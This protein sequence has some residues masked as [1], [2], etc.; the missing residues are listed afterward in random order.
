MPVNLAKLNGP[1]MPPKFRVV[2]KNTGKILAPD[3]I[4]M[5]ISTGRISCCD[6]NG[7]HCSFNTAEA[8]VIQSIGRKDRDGEEVFHGDVLEFDQAGFTSPERA[9][10]R[11]DILGM[12][13]RL[14]TSKGGVFP[15]SMCEKGRC[16]GN[17]FANPELMGEA[18]A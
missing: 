6:K 10:V 12:T 3:A 5:D 15:L 11:W 8:E 18:K 13:L 16:I 17:V 1:A 2:L 9:C 14:V 7:D 4:C